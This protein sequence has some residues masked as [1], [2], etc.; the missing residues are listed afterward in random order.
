M[1]VKAL[2]VVEE[3]TLYLTEPTKWEHLVAHDPD[4][5]LTTKTAKSFLK[6]YRNALW[7]LVR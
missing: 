3:D 4:S 7:K 1:A 2:L 5:E 6:R